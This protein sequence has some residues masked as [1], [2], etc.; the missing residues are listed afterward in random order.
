MK[1]QKTC[2]ARTKFTAIA[3]PKPNRKAVYMAIE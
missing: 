3:T 2:V 1:A